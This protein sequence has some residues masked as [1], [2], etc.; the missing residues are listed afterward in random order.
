MIVDCQT[1]PVRG[2]R[3]ED[4]VVT[5]L[6]IPGSSEVPLDATETR[7]VSA[8]VR[9]GL[10]S[11]EAAATVCARREPWEGISAVG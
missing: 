7:A 9:A 2:Q 10:M 1:C 4:C 3:C 8:F 5:A 11:V 6:F